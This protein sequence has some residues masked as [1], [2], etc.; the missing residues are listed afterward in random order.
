VHFLG[1]RADVADLLAASDVFALPSLSEGVPLALLEA[2]FAGKGIA[3]SDV[4]GVPEVVTS[5]REALLVPAQN[6]DLL[7]TALGRLLEDRTLRHRLGQ[8]ARQR[9]ER[10]FTVD[11]M[12]DAYVRLY[13]PAVESGVP[14]GR[15]PLSVGAGAGVEL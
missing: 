15:G 2:M 10:A 8:A 3:A 13:K 12:A 9:A 7:A 11:T 6:P 5:E 14:A 1:Y 4:G